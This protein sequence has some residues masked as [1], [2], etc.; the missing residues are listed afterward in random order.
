M[1]KT[2]AQE[3]PGVITT[4]D[5]ARHGLETGDFVTFTEVSLSTFLLHV[6][7]L[8]SLLEVSYACFI[9]AACTVIHVP[10]TACPRHIDD[11]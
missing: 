9:Y 11:S 1:T 10:H 8:H 6:C 5:E 2:C 3:N 4:L 7:L